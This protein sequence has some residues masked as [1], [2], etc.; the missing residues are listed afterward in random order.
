M[1]VQ[2]FTLGEVCNEDRSTGVSLAHGAEAHRAGHRHASRFFPR[3]V[4]L[5]R[6]HSSFQSSSLCRPALHCAVLMLLALLVERPRAHGRGTRYMS[7]VW[8]GLSRAAGSNPARAPLPWQLG[9][10]AD[11]ARSSTHMRR[12]RSRTA[13][14]ISICCAYECRSTV[15]PVR[16]R[17][18]NRTPLFAFGLARPLSFPSLTDPP[19]GL[20]LRLRPPLLSRQSSWYDVWSALCCCRQHGRGRQI[21]AWMHACARARDY[22]SAAPVVPQMQL[23]QH[24]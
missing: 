21:V 23:L 15:L 5:T 20:G 1:N 14:P 11:S 6:S 2:A 22:Q 16:R 24:C 13:T 9:G 10:K 18:T 3:P 19:P 12:S 8:A 4:D 17:Q 7:F